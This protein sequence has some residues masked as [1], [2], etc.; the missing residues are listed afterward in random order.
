MAR[1]SLSIC[2]YCKET[3]TNDLEYLLIIESIRHTGEN[4]QTHKA[5]ICNGCVNSISEQ[6]NQ[7]ISIFPGAAQRTPSEQRESPD[8]ITGDPSTELL[9]GEVTY[10]KSNFTEEKKRQA[11]ADMAKKCS[12]PR[13]F[14]MDETDGQGIIC[15]DCGE[16]VK[17]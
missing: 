10:T 9:A 11:I 17:F 5:E 6:L 8:F 4:K 15:K 2:D 14:S 13:G 16:K 12:H 7:E 1:I 3:T